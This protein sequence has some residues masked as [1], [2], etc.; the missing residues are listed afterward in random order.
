MKFTRD[1]LIETLSKSIAEVSFTKING[2]KRIMPC[3]L[4]E[5]YLPKGL[6]DVAQ[7]TRNDDV[8]CVWCTDVNGWRSFKVDLVTD[9][10]VLA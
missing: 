6:A 3:T 4:L 10:K 2:E 8:L 9:V 1:G 5:D 7:S